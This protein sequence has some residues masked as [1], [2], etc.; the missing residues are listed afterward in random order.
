VK[1]AC[2]RAGF[3]LQ[4]R[5]AGLSA[6][7]GLSLEEHLASCEVC[8][9]QANL[10]DGLRALHAHEVQALSGERRERV[11]G[12]ALAG[13]M[14][15][16][17]LP[18]ALPGQRPAV[19]L[20]LPAL[21]ALVFI[22]T[23][24]F[25]ADTS[26]GLREPAAPLA[27]LR[28][29]AAPRTAP[30]AQGDRVLSGQVDCS[31]TAYAAGQ[32]LAAD[33]QL[34]TL[35]D[36]ATLALAHATVSMRADTRAR[37]DA[38]R[39]ELQLNEGSV[40]LDVDPSAHA[41][42]SVATARFSV[43]V[44]GTRFDVSLDTVKV[45]R[46]RVQVLAP[47]GHQLA[48]LDASG[49]TEFRLDSAAA[50]K[51]REQPASGSAAGVKPEAPDSDALLERARSELGERNVVGARRTL[52]RVLVRAVS[53][54]QRA[55]AL[56]LRAEC[57][58]VAGKYR[59]ARDAY[60]SVADRFAALPAGETARFAAARIEAEHGEPSRALRLL[61]GYLERYPSGRFAKEATTRRQALGGGRP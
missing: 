5:A 6:A 54:E 14:N 28:E 30:L 52:Q 39:H 3:L 7:A 37:W 16:Q 21:A 22:G 38:S 48:L 57:E 32:P 58:L 46:G 44:L 20:L 24:A 41:R 9:G 42:F 51:P 47:D 23:R 55:E 19:W 34:H 1:P 33:A 8:R 15:A 31:G 13:A 29:P 60:L 4:R 56:S 26:A 35:A 49:Q 36:A 59:A 27:G 45:S 10:L 43:L 2:M 53:R 25:R 50:P 17:Q 61:A 40:S 11:I 18:A 12:L